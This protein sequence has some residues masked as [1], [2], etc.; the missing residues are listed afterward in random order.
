MKADRAHNPVISAILDG[1]AALCF[2]AGGLMLLA[3]I[4]KEYWVCASGASVIV[5][6]LLF[7]AL[8]EIVRSLA[9]ANDQRAHLLTQLQQ[10][11]KALQWIVDELSRKK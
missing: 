8:A 9:R 4:L 2:I 3:L 6:G 5:T 7:V 1:V 10:N 11:A